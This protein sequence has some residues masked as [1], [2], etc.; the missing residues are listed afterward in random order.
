MT[1]RSKGPRASQRTPIH[2]ACCALVATIASC[3][4]DGTHS[5]HVEVCHPNSD[6]WLGFSVEWWD[7]PLS[8]RMGGENCAELDRQRTD[9]ATYIAR[10]G[11]R[12]IAREDLDAS[13]C[14]WTAD[15]GH[16]P[17]ERVAITFRRYVLERGLVEEGGLP[18]V[19]CS[20]SP[21]DRPVSE[22]WLVQELWVDGAVRGR[23]DGEWFE[24]HAVERLT[25][26]VDR[27][28][29]DLRYEIVHSWSV[30][31]PIA[32]ARASMSLEV[33]DLPTNSVELG[34]QRCI[35]F[36]GQD[37][38]QVV[39]QREDLHVASAKLGIGS[40]NL[41]CG[42]PDGSGVWIFTD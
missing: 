17:A 9:S 20:L 2:G 24:A 18:A 11:G 31:S 6:E 1:R 3:G 23:R 25:D 40:S 29:P 16:D 15:L 35:E 7:D 39:L 8:R 14:D 21:P 5:F 22:R 10:L 37:A 33:D 42:F 32:D 12:E 34:F 4:A 41:F 26:Q 28:G 19:T 27:L 36:Q 38:A 30:D 13:A